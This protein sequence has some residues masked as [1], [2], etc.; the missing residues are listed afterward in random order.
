MGAGYTLASS[1]GM[2]EPGKVTPRLNGLA[3]RGVRRL[4]WSASPTL[5]IEVMLS[6]HPGVEKEEKGKVQDSSVELRC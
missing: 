5:Q 6:K 2:W 4:V 3:T 1:R